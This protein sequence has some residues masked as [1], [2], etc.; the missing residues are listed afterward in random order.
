MPN[1]KAHRVYRFSYV[2]ILTLAVAA[3]FF[4]LI[5]DFLI[6]IVLAAIFAGLLYPLFERSLPRFGGR[7]GLAAAAIVIFAVLIAGLPLA[8]IVAIVGAEAVQLSEASLA[9]LRSTV[10]HPETLFALLPDRLVRSED[11]KTAIAFI[12]GHIADIVNAL[13]HF[14]AVRLSALTLGAGRV[15]LDLFVISFGMV[16]F[17]QSGTAIVERLMER[18]PVTNAEAHVIVDKTLRLTAAALKGIV[19]VGTAQGILI[20]L[21]FAVAGIGQ[22]WF[23]GAV[24]AVA[25]TVPAV[26]SGLV[27]APAALYLVLTGHALTGMLLALWGWLSVL[28]GDTLLR[29]RSVGKSAAIP[30]FLVFISTLGGLSVLGPPGILIGPVLAGTLLGVLDL[31]S[32]VLKSSGLLDSPDRLNALD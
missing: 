32:S 8:A 5:R 12:N 16:Y 18:I 9:W 13:A 25:S 11:A 26:G 2:L 14:M 17:L 19:F 20:G 28:V 23:W 30:G 22:P 6:D 29:L 10:A 24:A 3:A 1:S 4:T 27:W 21:G 7:Q 31:Y 15:L